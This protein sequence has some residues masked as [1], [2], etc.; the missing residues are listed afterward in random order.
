MTT[1][2]SYKNVP[3]H[4]LLSAAAAA[5]A[6]MLMLGDREPGRFFVSSFAD[7]RPLRHR[8]HPNRARTTALVPQRF[9]KRRAAL[10]AGAASSSS[11][12]SS[13]EI[14]LDSD[15]WRTELS[16]DECQ[17]LL[18]TAETAARAAGVV[19]TA[20]LGCCSEES[21]ECEIKYSIKDIV[22]KH[23]R[24]AQTAIEG[25]VRSRYPDHS[26]LGEED[27]DPGAAASEAALAS[28]L[29]KS[30]S[31]F[32]WICDP[33]DGTANFAAGMPLCAV[34]M[35]IV[36]RGTPIVGVVYDPHRDEMFGAIR[37]RGATL[38]GVPIVNAASRTVT[39]VS[40]AL[41]NAGCPADPNAFEASMRGVLALNGRSR[42]LRIV[43][44]SALTT[45]WISCGRL[46]AHFGYDL[47]SWDLVAGALLIQEA[48]GIVTDLDGTPYRLE[49]RNML[50]SCNRQ[51]HDD[52]LKILREGDAVSFTRAPSSAE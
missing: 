15:A 35:G 42:G 21:D 43:A 23:D 18:K 41:I 4:L 14:R 6:L 11:A 52:V 3:R 29:A 51:L 9:G 17:D 20:N 26:L 31:D 7:V 5:A 28:V 40:D 47:S 38:N 1:T 16:Y 19:V 13:A 24:S 25:I 48:G 37:G 27:V 33:I 45:A 50:C 2:R 12:S 44:C 22:T 32:L 46:A 10:G 34:T 39:S 8:A 36:Y 49:T 30:E